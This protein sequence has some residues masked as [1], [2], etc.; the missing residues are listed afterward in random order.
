MRI[1]I[2]IKGAGMLRAQADRA[3]R[4]LRGLLKA[5]YPL[6][7]ATLRMACGAA[8]LQA[9]IQK[10]REATRVTIGEPARAK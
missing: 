1:F 2:K 5:G 9:T 3:R 7:T 4:G 6:N 8:N 10:G